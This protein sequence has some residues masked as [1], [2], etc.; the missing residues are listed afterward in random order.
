MCMAA[1]TSRAVMPRRRRIARIVVE[2]R[3]LSSTETGEAPFVSASIIC[4]PE[5]TVGET[6]Q[7]YRDEGRAAFWHIRRWILAELATF[8]DAGER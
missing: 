3:A 4:T 6:G 1:A 7:A 8:F 2:S 5:M